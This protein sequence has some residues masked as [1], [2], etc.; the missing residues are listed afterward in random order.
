[1]TMNCLLSLT[2]I[3]IKRKRL[4][5]NIVILFKPNI[6]TTVIK[7]NEIFNFYRIY[8]TDRHVICKIVYASPSMGIFKRNSKRWNS[9]QI[10][11]YF[12][13]LPQLVVEMNFVINFFFKFCF[14][15]IFH[16]LF[17]TSCSFEYAAMQIWW[18]RVYCWRHE[19]CY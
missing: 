15:T 17:I 14:E 9:W 4:N 12:V 3:A 8:K 6:S 1:M 7:I 18:S 2:N 11:S 16:S 5:Y 10:L 19:W 13:S